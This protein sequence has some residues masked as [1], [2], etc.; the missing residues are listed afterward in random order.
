MFWFII[1]AG[2]GFYCGIWGTLKIIHM[3]YPHIYREFENGEWKVKYYNAKA[4]AA[5]EEDKI[6]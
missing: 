2:L 5:E 4:K 1:G 3:T 6:L